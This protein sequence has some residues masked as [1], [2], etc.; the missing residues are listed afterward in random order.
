MY[1][2]L[3][4]LLFVM[5]S[6][7]T[8]S[9][10]HG[11]CE[12]I[13]QQVAQCNEKN[14]ELQNEN[15]KL[16]DQRRKYE[17]EAKRLR[18]DLEDC[19]AIRV[20]A[21][22]ERDGFADK[23]SSLKADLAK[24]KT[25]RQK[26][27]DSIRFRYTYIDDTIE[28]LRFRNGELERLLRYQQQSLADLQKELDASILEIDSLKGLAKDQVDLAEKII[29]FKGK[30]IDFGEEVI[31]VRARAED[32]KYV[33]DLA[34]KKDDLRRFANLMK[35]NRYK[36]RIDIYY[37]C[38]KEYKNFAEQVKKYLEATAKEIEPL[39]NTEFKSKDDWN[40]GVYIVI[41]RT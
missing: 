5:L 11:Q 35:R 34:S 3:Y 27:L 39:L 36:V 19:D 28:N 16:S 20:R 32:D 31:F 22:N 23:V 26:E 30:K 10:A 37:C 4:T 33:L 1:Q 8:A 14:R 25:I 38:Q 17:K 41:S 15:D 9:Q 21:E 2:P 7:A 40:M 29:Y 6:L 18:R 12:A 13:Q 24:Q